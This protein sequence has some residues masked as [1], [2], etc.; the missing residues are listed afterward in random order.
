MKQQGNSVFILGSILILLLFWQTTSVK[1]QEVEDEKEFDYAKGS[2]KGPERWGEIK[3]EWAACKHGEMQSPIDMVNRRVKI[4]RK[5]RELVSNYKPS[6]ATVKN[7]GHDISLMRNISD[8]IDKKEERHSGVID[9]REIKM[10]GKRYYRY[11][12]SLTV[13]PCTEG[14]VW[15]INKKVMTVSR[16]QVKLLREAVHDYAEENARPLQPL[17][18]REIYLYKRP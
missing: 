13:P 1:A 6:N 14:V 7:R 10:G 12:G 17:H 9:P 15:T 11:M 3:E 8:M 16:E 4:I 18:D 2:E 5:S